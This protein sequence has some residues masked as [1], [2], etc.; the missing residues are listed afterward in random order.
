MQHWFRC[1]TLL[2]LLHIVSYHNL[3]VLCGNKLSLYNASC[4]YFT[5]MSCFPEWTNDWFIMSILYVLLKHSFHIIRWVELL[6][7]QLKLLRK[8]E[9]CLQHWCYLLTPKWWNA[10]IVTDIVGASFPGF[11]SSRIYIESLQ[12]WPC[13]H[14]LLVLVSW[15]FVINLLTLGNNIDKCPL[16]CH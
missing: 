16:T 7:L 9:L 2:L 11:T 13:L 12:S 8:V 14:P 10:A 4:C 6:R 5:L 3:E 15:N 1:L